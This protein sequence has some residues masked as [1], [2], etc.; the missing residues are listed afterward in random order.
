MFTIAVGGFK[1]RERN[2]RSITVKSFLYLSVSER[3]WVDVNID[4]LHLPLRVEWQYGCSMG[5]WCDAAGR[6]PTF[7]AE[8]LCSCHLFL[9]SYKLLVIR[10]CESIPSVQDFIVF[11]SSV[12]LNKA[13]YELWY[14]C[15]RPGTVINSA[16][17]T[18]ILAVAEPQRWHWVTD[19][20]SS[21]KMYGLRYPWMK[22]I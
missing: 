20:S 3:I 19:I 15:Q 12:I 22:W 8:A 4:R 5:V 9:L 10:V 11:I 17:W 21:G 16:H 7:V 1:R 13:T 18:S 6:W 14:F 2:E